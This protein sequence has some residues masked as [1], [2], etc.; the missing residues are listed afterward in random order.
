[1][2][3][4]MLRLGVLIATGRFLKQR[5]KGLVL[6]LGTWIVLWF[7]H[8]EYVSYVEL[9][10]DRRWVM[11]ATLLKLALY[12]CSVGLYVLLVER[13]LWPR[14][15]KMPPPAGTHAT[16]SAG[17]TAAHDVHT[18]HPASP[19]TAPPNTTTP[20]TGDGF[21]FL[22]HTRKLRGSTD[23]LLGK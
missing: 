23:K 6:V 5:W 15:L 10:G 7:L 22:R 14:R 2:I 12:G 11:H 9:S 4:Q 13:R 16:S 8:S 21:D 1:M 3:N 20:H 18:P 19:H 17:A